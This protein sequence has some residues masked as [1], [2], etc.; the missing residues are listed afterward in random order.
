MK[1]LVVQRNI[2]L[3]FLFEQDFQRLHAISLKTS[4]FEDSNK[5]NEGKWNI[6]NWYILDPVVNHTSVVGTVYTCRREVNSH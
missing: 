4:K 2:S 5:Q 1:L 6:S 3:D